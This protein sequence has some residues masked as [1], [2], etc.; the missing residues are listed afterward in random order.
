MW[1]M[2]FFFPF[3]FVT[4]LITHLNQ[5]RTGKQRDLPD[6]ALLPRLAQCT[7]PNIGS[8]IAP[9]PHFHIAASIN[10]KT[11]IP[12]LPMMGLHGAAGG[13][14]FVVHWLGNKEITFE[15]AINSYLG[16]LR[17][18]ACPHVSENGSSENLC[19]DHTVDEEHHHHH[20]RTDNDADETLVLQNNHSELHDDALSGEFAWRITARLDSLVD[21]WRKRPEMVFSVHPLDGS[22][23]VWHLDGLDVGPAGHCRQLQ[24]CFSSR[25]PVAFPAGDANSLSEFVFLHTAPLPDHIA[26]LPVPSRASGFPRTSSDTPVPTTVGRPSLPRPSAWSPSARL[27]TKHAD[28]SLN[29]WALGLGEDY[30]AV[31]SV[32][33][34]ARYCGHRFQ[35]SGQACHAVLPLLLT[36]SHYAHAPTPTTPSQPCHNGN[37]SIAKYRTMDDGRIV[38]KP[39]CMS[40]QK[41]FPEDGFVE[42]PSVGHGAVR[43]E[44]ILWRV[45]PVSPL[46]YQGGVLELACVTSQYRT[47]FSHIAWLPTEVPAYCLEAG[48]KGFQYR[49]PA[50]DCPPWL[51]NRAGHHFRSGLY[52]SSDLL[53]L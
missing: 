6:A 48:R 21:E 37:C 5:W 42:K 38:G 52:F 41:P 8:A 3:F 29:Q 53:L 11:D 19:Q 14:P 30:C 2:F 23:L 16:Q 32:L 46:S 49:Q 4:Q 22:F 31:L 7:L 20:H 47:A 15:L 28:G 40:P 24:V 27:V 33:H 51:R 50:V 10:P 25:I 44:L 9:L 35:L 18:K 43:S 13:A 26:S 17:T 34:L 36:T 12:L 39:S 45:D 1:L